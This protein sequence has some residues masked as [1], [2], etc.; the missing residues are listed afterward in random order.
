[1]SGEIGQCRTSPHGEVRQEFWGG[2][3]SGA[4]REVRIPEAILVDLQGP[5]LRFQS[6]SRNSEFLSR[7]GRSGYASSAIAKGGLDNG[8]FF[9]GRRSDQTLPDLWRFCRRSL[10]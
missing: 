9:R 1:M 4:G 7:S 2:L 5:D 10:G 6:R 3:A 8:L